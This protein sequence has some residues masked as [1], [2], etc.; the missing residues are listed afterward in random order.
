M[1]ATCGRHIRRR[2][3]T[4]RISCNDEKEIMKTSQEI[5]QSFP[6]WKYCLYNSNLMDPA[7]AQSCFCLF[8][9]HL[10]I[11]NTLSVYEITTHI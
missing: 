7:K 2:A 10:Y 3:A 4:I 11:L 1:I 9:K 5:I 6:K 8:V